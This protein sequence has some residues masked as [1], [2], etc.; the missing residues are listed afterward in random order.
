MFSK[1][2]PV[3]R[4]AKKAG[5]LQR[6]LDT[7]LRK[8]GQSPR[9]PS[10]D[11]RGLVSSVLHL[12]RLATAELAVYKS[13]GSV[14]RSGTT[15]MQ[16]DLGTIDRQSMLL[17]YQLEGS[18]SPQ[19][20]DEMNRFQGLTRDLGG[21]IAELSLAMEGRRVPV[22]AGNSSLQDFDKVR[23]AWPRRFRNRE[24]GPTVAEVER[25]LELVGDVDLD[26]RVLMKRF[27]NVVRANRIDQEFEMRYRSN[28]PGRPWVYLAL[29]V[30]FPT[31][32]DVDAIRFRHD[33]CGTIY[34]A[35]TQPTWHIVWL[36][37]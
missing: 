31:Q 22:H 15:R 9:Q 19:P 8:L 7:V 27:I 26:D 30:G 29:S 3:D 18:P 1:N 10:K 4:V 34:V 33:C 6:S 24:R 14:S 2:H 20:I 16:A 17:M 32:E 23:R 5:Q 37:E 13:T 12:E 25:A 21:A 11:W 35:A 28:A 36:F